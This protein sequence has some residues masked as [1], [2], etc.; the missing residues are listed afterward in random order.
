MTFTEEDAQNDGKIKQEAGATMAQTAA[1]D[2]GELYDAFLE[3][4]SESGQSPSEVL[5]DYLVR[6]LSNEGFSERILQTEVDMMKIRADELRKEDLMF[7]KE[8][9]DEFDLMGSNDTHPIRE[10]VDRRLAAKGGSPLG[11]LT[12]GENN[13]GSTDKEV[14]MLEARMNR[15]EGMLEQIAEDDEPRQT[16]TEEETKSNRQSVDEL[17]SS[18]GD[19]SSDEDNGDD[20]SDDSGPESSVPINTEAG[21]EGDEE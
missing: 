20:V 8:I 7:V 11:G 1:K 15:I 6:A 5:G 21:V 13:N 4:C 18:D 17:F 19:S 3:V 16:N 9:A 12:G 10:L 2:G 14:E